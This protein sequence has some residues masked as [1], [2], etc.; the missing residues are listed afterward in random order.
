MASAVEQ[1]VAQAEASQHRSATVTDLVPLQA[2]DGRGLTGFYLVI[3]WI[4]GGYLVASLLGVARGARPATVRRAAIRLL[5][6]IPTRSC[7][8]SAVRWWWGPVLG[9]LTGHLL[10]LWWL[11]TLLV[12][13]AAA[14]T[15]AFQVLFGVLGIGV[16]VLVFV[17]LGN[18]SAGGAYQPALLPPF[19]RAI[20][21][22]LPN[23]AGTDSVRR[24]AYFDSHGIGGHL[25]V[26]IG[27]AVARRGGRAGRLS[28][29]AERGAG[30]LRSPGSR[31]MSVPE[32]PRAGLVGTGRL[33]AFSDGVLAV[34][35]TLLVLDLHAD[36]ADP[37][38]LAHQLAA[39]WPSFAAYV[40][41]F[42]IIGVIWVNHHA[43]F[44]LAAAAGPAVHV[45]Q[46][47]A[48]DVGEHHPVHH[49]HPG[50]LPARRRHGRQAGGTA[51]R[52]VHRGHG[53][54]L[55][56]DPAP[57]DPGRPAA[58]AG[59]AAEGRRAVRRFG[60]GSVLYPMVT[61]V[62]LLSPPLMLLLYAG[63]DRLLHL[64]NRHRFSPILTD[65]TPTACRLTGHFDGTMRSTDRIKHHSRSRC[66]D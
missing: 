3:G 17:I 60:I 12:L 2:G 33:E 51:V 16:T 40:L 50:R 42:F 22:A 66:G 5:A 31:R 39:E 32:T 35:I 44:A 53:D 27:Y 8:A 62:G 57:A 63:I 65:Q 58:A 55:H 25:A 18:P 9:A 45:L 52:R 20:S 41:S 54:Q 1:V 30:R 23:G 59:V 6:L 43:L 36:A 46:P 4:V 10:A 61:A 13:A 26:I 24:I 14:V 19:W 64:S 29:P 15:M 48:A 47:A 21:S 11:G 56:P 37:A 49:R 28:P 34:A 7:P 38:G